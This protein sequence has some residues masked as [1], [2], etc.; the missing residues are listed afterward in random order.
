MS[1]ERVRVVGN[2]KVNDSVNLTFEEGDQ[3]TKYLE[4]LKGNK[5]KS[6]L[7]II[8]GIEQREKQREPLLMA[9]HQ[10]MRQAT[11]GKDQLNSFDIQK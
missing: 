1:G 6:A 2:H 9:M 11:G 4:R 8:S 10:A 5:D 3:I 7:E